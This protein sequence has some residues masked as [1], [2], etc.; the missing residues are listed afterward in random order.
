MRD[1]FEL[2]YNLKS[3]NKIDISYLSFPGAHHYRILSRAEDIAVTL[4]VA[5]E[6][7]SAIVIYRLLFIRYWE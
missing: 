7:S 6:T 1:Q 4:K 3:Y 2:W 5:F